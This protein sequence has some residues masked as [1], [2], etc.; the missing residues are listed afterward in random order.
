MRRAVVVVVAGL[1]VAGA[2]L[3]GVWVLVAPPVHG[4]V[5][6]N[7]SG[8]RLHVYL[9]NE[10]DHF[11]VSAVMM[12]GLVIAVAVVA[13]VLVWQWRRRRGPAMVA[14]LVFGGVAAAA[15][16]TAVGAGLARLRYGAVDVATAPVSPQHRVYYVTEASTVFFGHA[17][18]QVLATLLLPAAAAAL[19]YATMVA[20]SAHDDL[21]VGDGAEPS[22]PE[23]VG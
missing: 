21:D 6:L 5:A 18:L 4:V 7:R 20:A 9:G 15:A 8:Q 22:V 2:L 16:A 19:T 3:G 11:F 12:V 17:P 14:G 1:A 10:A 23:A 13:A